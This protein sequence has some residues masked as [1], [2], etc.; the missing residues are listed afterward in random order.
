[1]GVDLSGGQLRHARARLPVAR[2]DATALPLS[3]GAVPAVA[4][5]LAH[6]DMPD[7]PAA[8][9]EA[10]RVLAPGGRLA[11]VGVPRVSWAPSPTGP[12]RSGS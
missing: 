7:Y 8:V 5:V 12:S 6:T 4:C 2:A 3:T 11:H 1:M 10:A 9:A